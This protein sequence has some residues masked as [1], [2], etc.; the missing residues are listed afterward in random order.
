[1]DCCDFNGA[2]YASV[3]LG[4][5]IGRLLKDIPKQ[6]PPPPAVRPVLAHVSGPWA[7]LPLLF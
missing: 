5:C 3:H 6:A 7:Q 1:M 4:S 2:C